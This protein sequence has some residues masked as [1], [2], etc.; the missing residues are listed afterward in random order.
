[1]V[2]TRMK[3]VEI[4]PNDWAVC[5]RFGLGEI[6]GYQDILREMLGIIHRVFNSLCILFCV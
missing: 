1:M 2:Y 3:C 4:G 6:S 5:W